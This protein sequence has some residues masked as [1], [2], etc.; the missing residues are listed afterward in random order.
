MFAALSGF[1]HAAQ[2]LKIY[3]ICASG[4]SGGFTDSVD[5]DVGQVILHTT[6]VG[7]IPDGR[8]NIHL[9]T[10]A[11]AFVDVAGGVIT[12]GQDHVVFSD[13]AFYVGI[14]GT[15]A[16]ISIPPQNYVTGGRP[17]DGF[18]GIDGEH[19]DCCAYGCAPAVTYNQILNAYVGPTATPGA[20]T[21]CNAPKVGGNANNCS[22]CSGGQTVGPNAPGMARYTVHSKLVSLNIQ[23]TPLRYSPAYGPSVDFTVTYNQKESQ[24]PATFNYSNLGPKWTFAWLSYVSD[25]PTVQLPFTGLYRSGGGAEIFAYDSASQS[26]AADPR[27]HAVLVKT[28]AASYERRLPDGSKEVFALSD[29]A[30]SFP[31]RIFMTQ[32]I[33][34]AGNAVTIGYD[35]SFRVRTVT[36]ALSQ[37]TNISYELPSDSLKITKVTDPFGRFASFEYTNGELTKITDEIGIQ[38]QFTYT[39]GTDSIDSLHTPYGTTTF[40]SGENGTN[41]W[42]EMT[43]PLG[44][45]ERVEYRDHAPGIS[46]SDSI[47]P[48]VAGV[49]NAGLDVAN[50]FYWDKKAMLVAPGNYTQAKITHWLYNADGTVSDIIS[51]EKQPLENRVWSTYADQPDYQHAGPSANPTQIARVLGDGTQLNQF[52]YNSLGNPTKSTDPIGRVISYVYDTNNIDRLEIRQTRGTNNELLRKFTYNARHEPLTDTDAAGQPTTYTYNAQ[53]QVLTRQN[54]RNETTTYVYGDNVPT[55]CLARIISPAF[56]GVS[57][58]TQFGYDSYNRVRSVTN[59]ADDYT[60]TTDYDN[61][62]RKIQ[63]TY[64]DGTFEQFQY[65]DNITGAMTLDLT[66][67]SDRLGRWTFRHYDANQ[68]MDSITDPLNRTTIYGWCTCGSLTSIED[69]NHNVTTF[70]RD[71]QSR[72]YQKVF[73]DSSTIDYLFEGQTAPNTAGATSRLKSSTDANGQTTNYSYFAD[74]NLQQISYSNALHP[75]PTVNYSYDQNYNRIICMTD[76]I[77]S[78]HYHYYPVAAGTMGAGQLYQV[79]GPFM[80]DTITYA[81]DELGRT[82]G[83]DIDGTGASM[84]YDSLGRLGTTTNALGSF[85]RAY[86]G[87]TPRLGSV[88]YPNGQMANYSYYDNDNDRRLQT[89]QYVTSSDVNLSSHEYTYDAEGQIQSWSKTLGPTQTS[90]SFEYDDAKQLIGVGQTGVG[91][92]YTYDDAGNRLTNSFYGAHNVHSNAT[93]TANNLNQLDSVVSNSFGPTETDPVPLTYDHNGNLTYDGVN[94]TFEWDAANRLVA[95]NYTDSGSRTEFAYDGLGRRLKIIEK[96]PGLTAVVQPVTG[97]YSLFTTAPVTLSQG[98]YTIRFQGLDPNGTGNIMLLDQAALNGVLVPDGGFENPVVDQAEFNPSET[99]WTYDG[100]SGVTANGSKMTRLSPESSPEGNQVAFIQGDGAI[101]QSLNLNGAYTLSFAAIQ[102]A[103]GDLAVSPADPIDGGQPGSNETYQQIRVTVERSVEATTV[104]T[105]VWCGNQI[106]E[107][108]DITGATVTKRYF[109]EGEQRLEGD[110]ANYYYTRDHLGS[111]REVTTS[112]GSVVARYDYD[113]WG[114][115]FVVNGN[116]TVDFGYTGHYFHQPSGLNLAMY[117]AYSPTMGRWISRDPLTNAEFKQGPNL[118]RYVGNSP[119]NRTDP[120]GLQAKN[121]TDALG[122][123]LGNTGDSA[124]NTIRQEYARGLAACERIPH[125]SNHCCKCCVISMLVQFSGPF[126]LA[127]NGWG[128]VYDKPCDEVTPEFI[129]PTGVETFWEKRSW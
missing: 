42:I 17:T 102:L 123:L 120:T 89:L 121:P 18:V 46:A 62:D 75:T 39:P 36:D 127:T 24:Q 92:S 51:S 27:S 59:V 96:G 21:T 56:N 85:T 29:G 115:S 93:Y 71:I 76:G 88:N 112:L 4:G 25:D 108:R 73:A 58:V 49:T 68:H 113:A 53:G 83:Q 110:S 80:N 14:G 74:D 11:D 128:Q 50:T 78:T 34:P 28:G 67:S 69:P 47:A 104:K 2:P 20:Q 64:P 91:Y 122:N 118:Y 52:E 32:M 12:F 116:L 117:R 100:T 63:V 119:E 61:L 60:V 23:D 8:Y 107:E 101:S 45:K 125:S 13:N 55:G 33:D 99:A 82:I 9:S 5:D 103:N 95:I 111:I 16:P 126:V 109:A 54:A 106:C 90:S 22:S 57:A 98:N 48:N 3:Y 41:R 114:K 44:G 105:F 84:S 30:T 10:G 37:V 35:G 97:S 65:T 94:Q 7:S 77:G 1:A 72:I 81:Y 66:G 43:D 79:D 70:N 129:T 26:F 38:S 40:V 86:Y 87:V 124:A 6:L 15:F 19:Y 31:R